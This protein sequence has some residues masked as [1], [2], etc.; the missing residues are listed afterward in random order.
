MVVSLCSRLQRQ[1]TAD[2]CEAYTALWQ[3]T[4]RMTKRFVEECPGDYRF[5]LLRANFLEDASRTDEARVVYRQ[6]C[7]ATNVPEHVRVNI[8][9]E[10]EMKPQPE[11]PPYR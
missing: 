7:E 5:L 6:A 1:E 4:D 9:A 8:Q 11:G 10:M 3:G 2:Y